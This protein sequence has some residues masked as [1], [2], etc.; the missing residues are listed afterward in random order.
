MQGRAFLV[1]YAD[2][3]VIGFTEDED[4]QRVMAVLPKRFGKYGLTIHPDKT[5]LVPFRKPEGSP[6]PPDSAGNGGAGDVQLPGFHAFLGAFPQRELGREA[7]DG[8]QPV[9]AGS[10]D[11]RPVV[12]AAPPRPGKEQQ[13]YFARNS[14]GTTHITGSRAT[15]RRCPVS[16]TRC[17]GSG[18]SGS[19]GGGE[20]GAEYPAGS[21]GS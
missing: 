3:F 11:D 4:A 20:R 13:P 15:A 7:E 12:P 19:P 10:K 5:R 8:G 17:S 14:V 21:A 16:N 1:R 6:H 18:A 9:H 2:D